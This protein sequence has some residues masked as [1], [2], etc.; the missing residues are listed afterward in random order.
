MQ[1]GMVGLGRMGANM[2]RRLLKNGHECVVHDSQQTAVDSLAQDGATASSTMGD[3]VTKLAKPRVVWLMI[4]AA[5][6][7]LALGDLVPLLDAGDIVVDGGNSYYGDDMRRGTKLRAA[8]IHYLDVGTSGGVA[9]LERGYCLMIGGDAGTFEHLRPIFSA[10]APGS[11]AA[12]RTP[13]RTGVTGDAEEGFLHCGPQG[14]GHFVKMVH[15]G[16]EYGVMAAYAEGLNILRH[17][18]V[19]NERQHPAEHDAET[20]PLH[21]PGLYQFEMN[22]P[23][24]A[25]VWRRGS[26]IGS[27]LLDLT[28]SALLKSPALALYNG[29][30]SDS[31]EG[32]WT[33]R[34]AID[35]GVP[36]P[37]LS[38]ALYERFT[39]RGNADF[40]NRIVS[41]MRQE[42]GGHVEKPSP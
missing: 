38:A 11:A 10:L 14:A 1:I 3:M 16:I 29:R 22:L 9:G 21:D 19:G 6:V 5:V 39:S 30:V 8:G 12:T 40:A 31:G 4:P 7:D 27:W 13:G 34:A 41:A 23:E 2:V 18:N 32:R 35:E 37:V 24:I 15:N 26:V 33:I 20:T 25:E 17:A 28:A 36:A 42:F